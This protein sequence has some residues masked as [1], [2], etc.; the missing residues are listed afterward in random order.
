MRLGTNLSTAAYGWTFPL[1]FG[2]SLGAGLELHSIW[3]SITKGT[4]TDDRVGDLI[5]ARY[6][7]VT[8]EIT[9]TN[10]TNPYVRIIWF[11]SR[12]GINYAL[13]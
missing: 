5:F 8:L 10:A 11:K 13:N 1:T 9:V 2:S 6:L 3:A 4:D 7:R 12:K